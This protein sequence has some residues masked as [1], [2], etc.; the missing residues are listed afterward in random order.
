MS[1]LS[2]TQNNAAK[3]GRSKKFT[4]SNVR[5]LI[6]GGGVAGLSAAMRLK[7]R[8]VLDVTILEGSDRLGGRINTIP[9][10]T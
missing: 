2:V 3:S 4:P 6:V 10:S 7:E 9:Y 8:K 5:V 1:A